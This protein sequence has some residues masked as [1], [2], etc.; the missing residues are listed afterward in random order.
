M[1]VSP[2]MSTQLNSNYP[3]VY[4]RNLYESGGTMPKQPPP[5]P[6]KKSY[7]KHSQSFTA[8]DT[9]PA[10]PKRLDRKPV[11]TSKPPMPNPR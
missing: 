4:G 3:V 2:E 5:I 10:V 7:A 8:Y 11:N 1:T 9:R 6:A